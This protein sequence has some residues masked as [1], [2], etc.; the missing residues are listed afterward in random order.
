[1]RIG[2]DIDGCLTDCAKFVIDYGTKFC[3]ENNIDYKITE[4]EYDEAKALGISYEDTEKFWNKY[5][6]YYV[7]EYKPREFA[8]EIINKLKQNNEIYIITARNEYGLP[9]EHYGHMQDFVK[10]W[11]EDNDIYYDKLIFTMGSKLP[12]CMENKIDIMVEDS[13]KNVLDVSKEIEVLC[14]DNPYNKKIEGNNIERVYSWYD[15]YSK[16]SCN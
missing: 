13:P 6:P 16:I 11:L 8:P 9:P 3:V 1:M 7:I 12:Y 14:F 2:I 4:N 15:V 10:K 5:L